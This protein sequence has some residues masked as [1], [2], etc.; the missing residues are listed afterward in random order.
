MARVLILSPGPDNG[1]VGIGIKRAFDRYAPGWEVRVAVRRRIWFGWD[2]DILWDRR[3]A[4]LVAGLF[5]RADVVH[6]METP[7][8]VE[9]FAGWERKPRIIHH[10][11]AIYRAHAAEFDGRAARE[12]IAAYG[13]TFELA[14][15]GH[16]RWLPHP[17]D[18]EQ[19]QRQVRPATRTKPVIA[20]SPSAR[21]VNDTDALAAA[22]AT[23]RIP[24]DLRLIER[25]PWRA[26]L[27]AKAGAD[28]VFDSLATGYGMT[29]AEAWGMGI[30]GIAGADDP[31]VLA[32]M[33]AAIG[34]VPY[35]PVTRAGL[36]DEVATFAADPEL[37]RE[38]AER[39]AATVAAHHAEPRIVERLV[40]AY[41][42]AIG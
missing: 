19:M 27:A 40:A 20:Q 6:M 11:G 3:S 42:E 39:G 1:G 31:A 26:H 10:H 30:P 41:E 37:R 29:L 9:T 5:R 23:G 35:Y 22:F 8:V 21:S 2:T 34:H 25:L 12:G 16:L 38:Y 36:V 28:A 14:S 15:A 17:V 7:A 4:D 32:V 24:A 13:A 18:L 33:L